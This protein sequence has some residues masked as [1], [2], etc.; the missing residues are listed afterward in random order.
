[1]YHGAPAERAELRRTVMREPDDG[2]EALAAPGERIMAP[3]AKA[4]QKRRGKKGKGKA[5]TPATKTRKR[6]KVDTDDEEEEEEDEGRLPTTSH[7]SR[8]AVSPETKETFPVVV[9]TY[10]M[11][12]HLFDVV[13]HHW[14]RFA[15]PRVG[16]SSFISCPKYIQWN[17]PDYLRYC[18]P[19]PSLNRS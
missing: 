10:K 16:S 8:S 13:P 15:H 7:Y 4:S 6:R 12:N 19:G 11:I 1:M 14:K 5:K 2:S 9:T 18:V 17:I 3:R